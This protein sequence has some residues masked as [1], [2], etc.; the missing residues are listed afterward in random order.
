MAARQG[1]DGVAVIA[2][3][4][5]TPFAKFTGKLAVLPATMVKQTYH[6]RIFG[7]TSEQVAA[8]GLYNLALA[9]CFIGVWEELMGMAIYTINPSLADQEHATVWPPSRSPTISSSASQPGVPSS[10]A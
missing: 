5:R 1:Q 3:Y 7:A 8:R 4:A 6:L 9:G 2:G 10:R